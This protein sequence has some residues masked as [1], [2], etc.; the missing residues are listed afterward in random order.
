MGGGEKGEG[1]RDQ[2]NATTNIRRPPFIGTDPMPFSV[3]L[4]V[5]R[6]ENS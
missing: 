5:L 2:Y 6:G 1:L 4:R 3:L